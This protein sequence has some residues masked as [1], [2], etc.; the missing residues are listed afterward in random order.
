MFTTPYEA[1][2]KESENAICSSPFENCLQAAGAQYW[3]LEHSLPKALI[4][5]ELGQVLDE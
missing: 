1:M 2:S 3:E 5:D 4:P